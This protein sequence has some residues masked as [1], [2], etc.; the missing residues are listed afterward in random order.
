M[1]EKILENIPPML[2][3]KKL[4]DALGI[5][6]IYEK[7]I[8]EQSPA[9]RLIALNTIYD[10]YMPSNMSQEIYTH[11]Y[12]AMIRSL[13]KKES[14]L[15]MEQRAINARAI[16]NNTYS[17]G[18][19]IGGSDSFSIIGS[20]GIGK[21]R[22][23]ER[24]IAIAG[25]NDVIEVEG[26]YRKIIPI[27]NVQCPYD[28][29][30]K[31]MLL[32]ICKKI[33]DAIGSSYYEMEVKARAST[34]LMIVSVSQILLNHC[35]VLVIDEVQNLVKHRAGMQLVSMLTQLLN[36]SGISIVLVGTPEVESFFSEVDYL[37]R[38]TIGL[39]YDKLPYDEQWIM[40]CQSLWEYQFTSH[41]VELTDAITIYLYEH[42]SGTI[43][44]LL[45]LFYTAQEI[46]ILNGTEVIDLA[47]LDEAYQR[48][49]MLHGHIEPVMSV[50]SRPS[51]RKKEKTIE[52]LSNVQDAGESS[53]EIYAVQDNN[54]EWSF[55][56]LAIISKKKN[57]DILMLLKGKVSI[58]AIA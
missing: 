46:S 56:E 24:A 25:G 14:K 42:T 9:D 20:P 21:S 40:L 2:V 10:F 32:S 8:K 7:G 11:I 1:D 36:E 49:R 6:P 12:L 31:A 4:I 30:V 41:K 57:T 37:A 3:G 50:K 47:S 54:E 15:A 18:G 23:I 28:C 43:S 52:N 35:A 58:T 34:N 17:N 55:E 29:S 33:D 26:P 13:K 5:E 53:I 45:Y 19:I 16:R 39:R 27:I 48:M 22:S 51:K 44:H 38:R